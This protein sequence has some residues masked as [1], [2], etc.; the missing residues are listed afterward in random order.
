VSRIRSQ[1]PA[2]LADQLAR[3]GEFAE[4]EL[5]TGGEGGYVAYGWLED[6]SAWVIAAP[7]ARLG[8]DY[9]AD[10]LDRWRI[11][12]SD[13]LQTAVVTLAQLVTARPEL[14]PWALRRHES[15]IDWLN[16]QNSSIAEQQA[17][18]LN[19]ELREAQRPWR[20][21]PALDR[22]PLARVTRRLRP[23]ELR[24]RAALAAPP[25]GESSPPQPAPVVVEQPDLRAV[26]SS[27]P[28]GVSATVDRVRASAVV[29]LVVISGRD[30]SD[31][32]ES[33]RLWI[34]VVHA[35]VTSRGSATIGL[36]QDFAEDGIDAQ[37]F[38]DVDVL[39]TAL[40]GEMTLSVQGANA[41]TR[42]C[43]E[44]LADLMDPGSDP[45]RELR[46]AVDR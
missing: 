39:R 24:L 42:S 33:V 9:T 13:D 38:D 40:P 25:S 6:D 10:D 34:P 28:G 27:V 36:D 30:S 43:W 31:T 15:V 35:G 18:Q 45:A 5:T 12:H 17:Q 4:L 44:T 46:A 19:A 1:D 41:M 14:E 20:A 37:P 29:V 21:E 3:C 7:A 26:L 2:G 32:M 8:P 23:G 16:R 22:T 11:R